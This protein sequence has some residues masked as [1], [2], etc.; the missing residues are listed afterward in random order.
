MNELEFVIVP[1]ALQRRESLVR[2]D[3]LPQLPHVPIF[4]AARQCLGLAEARPSEMQ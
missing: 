1:A 4:F 3:V 2:G